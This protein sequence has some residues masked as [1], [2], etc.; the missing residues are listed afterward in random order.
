[1][2]RSFK[3]NLVPSMKVRFVQGG[4]MVFMCNHVELPELSSAEL[5]VKTQGSFK[6]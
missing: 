4:E 6:G 5:P 3:V 1:M 2:V